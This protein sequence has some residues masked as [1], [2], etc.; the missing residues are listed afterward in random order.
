MTTDGNVDGGDNSDI[1]F[2]LGSLSQSGTLTEGVDYLV[3]LDIGG[4]TGSVIVALDGG[5]SESFDAGSGVSTFT[6]QWENESDNKIVITPSID[7]DGTI[8]DI[9]IKQI[10]VYAKPGNCGGIWSFV[11]A[12][13]FYQGQDNGIALRLENQNS[14]GSYS[15]AASI[16]LP[17]Q[18]QTE[19]GPQYWSG[20]YSDITDAT[21]GIDFSGTTPTLPV[22][23]ETD[24]IP[25][26]SMLQKK[27]FSQ[28]EYK[29]STP[30]AVNESVSIEYRKNSTDSWTSCGNAIVDAAEQLSGYFRANFQNTQW[31]QLRI[32]LTP[33]GDS[34]SSFVRLKQIRL[35]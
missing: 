11:P 22:V 16:L 21:Y 2:V 12:N 14:Y 24:L 23:I 18:I 26:G 9:S 32:T 28:I 3:S 4:S 20:W 27:T 10:V 7:F 33:S 34:T 1:V 25:S 15:G 6:G 35:R 5:D 17:S 13:N 29:L 8:T 31:L 30:L 19:I